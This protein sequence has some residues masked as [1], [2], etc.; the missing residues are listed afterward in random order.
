MKMCCTC[1]KIASYIWE[2]P[3]AITSTNMAKKKQS[4]RMKEICAPNMDAVHEVLRSFLSTFD[5]ILNVSTHTKFVWWTKKIKVP[6][7][8]KGKCHVLHFFQVRSHGI[9]ELFPNCNPW[10]VI[11]LEKL[12]ATD[13]SWFYVQLHWKI[14]LY[15]P[16]CYMNQ[17][18]FLFDWTKPLFLSS[19]YL[20]FWVLL[21][22][23][24]KSTSKMVFHQTFFLPYI[25][26]DI[27]I[28]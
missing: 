24:L 18:R 11:Q 9:R 17:G 25:Y 19:V 20:Y 16:Y 3:E 23:F 22:L 28:M 10:R 27:D 4:N 6:N 15:L 5:K 8:G 1:L 14:T 26:I 12:F 13:E 21:F 2:N 7:D